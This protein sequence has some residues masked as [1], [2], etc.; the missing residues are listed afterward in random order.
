MES[1]TPGGVR[2]PSR[3]HL[4]LRLFLLHLGLGA[5][6]RAVL[7]FGFREGGVEP[8]SILGVV[9]L[10]LVRD[11][12]VAPFL[13]APAAALLGFLPARLLFRARAMMLVCF[14]ACFG[15]SFDAVVQGCFFEE[16]T[17]RYNHVAVDYVLYPHEVLVNLQESYPVPAILAACAAAAAVAAWLFA[18][19]LREVRGLSWRGRAAWSGGWIAAGAVGATLLV[20]LPTRSFADRASDEVAHNGHEQLWRAWATAELD[21]AAYYRTLPREAADARARAM[22][23]L[24]SAQP[25]REFLPRATPGEDLDVVVVV[26][27]SLGS[28]FSAF[29]GGAKHITPRLDEWSGRGLALTRLVA[30]GNRTVRGLEGILCSFPPLPGDS[31]TKRPATSH[32]ATLAEVY[33][34]LGYDTVFAYGGRGMFDSLEPFASNNGWGEFIDQSSMP[35]DAFYTAWGAADEWIFARLLERQKRAR[36]EG[37]RLFATLLSVSN[38][39]PYLVPER[40]TH[41]DARIGTREGAVAYADWS[42][43]R[44]LD[45]CR[46]EGLLEGTLVLVVGDHG[47]RVYGAESIPVGSYRIPALFLSPDEGLRGKRIERLCSQID[48]APTLL[49]LSGV[50]ATATFFG[51]D[52]LGLPSDGPGRAWVIHNRSIGLLTDEWM[53]VLGLQKEVSW[54]R[55]ANRDSTKL[56]LVDPGAVPAELLGLQDDA[57]AVFQLADE[58]YRERRLGVLEARRG[59]IASR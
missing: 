5:A 49:S 2:A 33:H 31:I 56:E 26:E 24:D 14:A 46:D 23:G 50:S 22:V 39:K 17:A 11:A 45:Q 43:G 36:T 20:A 48:L 44:W 25:M 18:R 13:L 40:D 9:A 6:L 41:V 16:F 55:R 4:L 21:Y 34:A 38:H 12:C 37:R 10:G 27:E 47:A 1:T 57:T 52:L 28:D 42:L 59:P 3:R 58:L 54:W 51:Q 15:L 30:D 29:Y 35:D 19:D 32:V 8:T 7:W 53:V